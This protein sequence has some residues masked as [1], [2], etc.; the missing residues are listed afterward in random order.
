MALVA[1]T[2]ILVSTPARAHHSFGAIYLESD[3][4]EIDGDVVEFQYKNPHSWLQI[5]S[6]DPFGKQVVY[7]AEWGSVPALERQGVVRGSLRVGDHVRVWASPAK[8][9]ADTRV[10]LKR[11]QLPD[12]RLI[13]APNRDDSGSATDR[14]N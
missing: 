2:L 6:R 5:E 3:T 10:R 11:I 7:A 4:I 8:N 13:G 9:P 14:R 1:C 12:G